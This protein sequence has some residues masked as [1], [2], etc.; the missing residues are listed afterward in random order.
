MTTLHGTRIVLRPITLADVPVLEAIR[1]EPSVVRWWGVLDD[2]EITEDLTDTDKEVLAIEVDGAVLGAIQWYQ[3]TEPAFRHAGMDIYL[4]T[5]AQ[6]GGIGT[7][8]VRLLAGHLIT[9]HGFHRLVIDPAAANERAIRAYAKVGFQPAGTWRRSWCGP[10]G[11]WEDQLL[12]DLLA[13][14]LR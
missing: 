5:A 11:V 2:G 6:G 12:M 1:R 8:A 3:E 7:E 9:E 13:E 14:E 10:D 4:S